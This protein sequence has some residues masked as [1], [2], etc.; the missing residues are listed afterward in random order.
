MLIA[1]VARERI[2][3]SWRLN[4]ANNFH[5]KFMFASIHARFNMN[6]PLYVALKIMKK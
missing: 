2:C 3:L 5:P 6:C 1:G 4:G